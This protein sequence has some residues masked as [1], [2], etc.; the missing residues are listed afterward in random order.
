MTQLHRI[1]KD[2]FFMLK[3]RVVRLNQFLSLVKMIR[4]MIAY[5]IK[6]ITV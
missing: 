2:N 5:R 6:L 3:K 1:I 4:V